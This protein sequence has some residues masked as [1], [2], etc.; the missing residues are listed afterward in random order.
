MQM[1]VLEM[2]RC[3]Q[4]HLKFGS[5]FEIRQWMEA[6]VILKSTRKKPQIV[7][8]RQVQIGAFRMLPEMAQSEVKKYVGMW[9]KGDPYH[10]VAGS[11]AKLHLY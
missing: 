6:G 3:L 9:R 4:K 5:S 11:L 2:G 10:V 7:L 1:L 8:N